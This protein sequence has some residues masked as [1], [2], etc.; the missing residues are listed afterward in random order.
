MGKAP[1]G[2]RKIKTRVYG[3]IPDKPKKMRIR[4]PSPPPSP[5][6][7]PTAMNTGNN[8]EF[9]NMFSKMKVSKGRTKKMPKTRRTI[10]LQQTR[11]TRQSIRPG[12]GK[13]GQA[14][15]RLERY[16]DESTQLT[17]KNK[18]KRKEKKEFKKS[19][20]NNLSSLISG[21]SVGSKSTRRKSTRK[22]SKRR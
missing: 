9:T 2:T 8:A 10:T 17:Q 7:P 6:R 3:R 13:S 16:I 21:F 22:N 14:K 20:N 12:R 1:T 5:P 19:V 11:P 18:N 15:E 4:I